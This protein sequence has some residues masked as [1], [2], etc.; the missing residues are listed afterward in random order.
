MVRHPITRTS[1]VK[2]PATGAVREQVRVVRE[3]LARRFVNKQ[4]GRIRRMFAWAVEAELLP[5]E[6]H[7]ALL[8]VQGLKKGKGE[9]REKAR[10][11]PVPEAYVEAVLPHVPATVRTM[12]EVQRLCGCR[13]QDVVNLRAID[14]DMTEPVWEFR[15]SRYKTEHHNDASDPDR[16]RVVYLGP[17]AQAFLKPYLTLNVTDYLFS[18]KRSEAERLTAKRAARKTKLW[19]SHARH[20]AKKRGSR[21]R[22]PLRDCYDV[23][24]YRRA[25]RRGCLK[26]GV[27]VW[28]PLQLRHA[29]GTEIRRGYGL[30][31]SQAVLGHSELGVTQVYAEVDRDTARRIMAEIG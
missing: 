2:D 4:I 29:R 13:P 24:S 17:K 26:A 28:F 9:A 31:A 19:P 22:A 27:P 5:V 7:Q 1:K 15:P 12:I 16:E 25:I 30:E 3:G 20:Q 11:K 10:V 21:P 6:V 23:A 8:R 18:P 14:I